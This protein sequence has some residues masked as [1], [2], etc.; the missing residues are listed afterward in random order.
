MCVDKC[1]FGALIEWGTH[2][3]RCSTIY[4]DYCWCFFSHKLSRRCCCVGECLRIFR[5]DWG[6]QF[7]RTLRMRDIYFNRTLF[8][9]T[10]RLCC[11]AIDAAD[12]NKAKCGAAIRQR[13]RSMIK[14]VCTSQPS[15]DA[16]SITHRHLNRTDRTVNKITHTSHTINTSKRHRKLGTKCRSSEQV[17][18]ILLFWL[19]FL[20]EG[21]KKQ[22]IAIAEVR[23]HSV[24]VH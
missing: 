7:F 3:S 23:S 17:C 22:W 9:V 24:N 13:A 5:V 8:V 16:A 19:S 4:F 6:W 12:V 10:D 21:R 11:F 15:S 2:L 14:I 1:N 20:N 18:A